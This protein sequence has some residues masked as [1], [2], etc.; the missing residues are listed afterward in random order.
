MKLKGTTSRWLQGLAVLH[1]WISG[2]PA[3]R[4]SKSIKTPV[5][6][7]RALRHRREMPLIATSGS[8]YF[9]YLMMTVGKACGDAKYRPFDFAS[10]RMRPISPPPSFFHPSKPVG[11]TTLLPLSLLS[12]RL[13]QA[14]GTSYTVLVIRACI[15]NSRGAFTTYA[16]LG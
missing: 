9:S 1:G 12:H 11:N 13:T 16:R 7:P 5:S 14:S 2:Q 10:S 6:K 15:Q 3:K 4:C 8:H